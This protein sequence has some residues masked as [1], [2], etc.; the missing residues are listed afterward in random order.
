[1]KSTTKRLIDQKANNL[2]KICSDEKFQK[3]KQFST[4]SEIKLKIKPQIQ[5]INKNKARSLLDFSL[6]TLSNLFILKICFNSESRSALNLGVNLSD[7]SSDNT[8]AEKLNTAQK[9]D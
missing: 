9:P 4:K 1:M 2:L 5:Y 3:V 8:D 7:V 6:F